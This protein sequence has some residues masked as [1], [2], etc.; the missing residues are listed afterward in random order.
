MSEQGVHILIEHAEGR[1]VPC[2]PQIIIPIKEALNTRDPEVL[3][4]VLRVM[5]RLAK[6]DLVGEALVPY[7]R[8]LLPVLN[9]FS[10]VR[11]NTGD[12]IDYGQV[13]FFSKP[14]ICIFY[15]ELIKPMS[16]PH[17]EKTMTWVS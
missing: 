6:C 8:Q 5:Q 1:I 3:C 2:V 4:R 15:R 16:Q 13:F 17:S 10:G 11:H 9:L 7:Y 12:Q 14:D